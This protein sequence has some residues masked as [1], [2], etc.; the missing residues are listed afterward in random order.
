M[1]FALLGDVHGNA[2]ALEAVLGAASRAGVQEL[3][4]T[5][6]LIGYYFEPS[7]VLKLLEPWRMHVV[8]G[9]HEEMLRKVREAPLALEEIEQKYGSGLRVAIEDLTAEQQD[10]LCHLPHPQRIRIGDHGILLCHGSPW[11]IDL[12]VYPDASTELLEQCGSSG[13]KLIVLG[14]TH[15]PMMVEFN[16]VRIVNPGS[17]GQPR[18]GKPGAHWALYDSEL[19]SLEFRVEHYDCRAL[20]ADCR[21]RHPEIP[22]LSDVLERTR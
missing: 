4:I 16:G 15:Y 6:D 3:L 11:D 14:H 20:V 1:R 12:Y 13:D 19:D 18:N 8:R 9:N 22:Y 2:T 17:V 7:E 21:R 5:G 10:W